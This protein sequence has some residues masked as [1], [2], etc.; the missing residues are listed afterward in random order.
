[1][2]LTVMELWM[3]IDECATKLFGLLREYNPGILPEILDVLQLPRYQDMC[4]LQ[5][6]QAYLQD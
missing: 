1:M 2:L 5:K 6:I 3:S 4:R